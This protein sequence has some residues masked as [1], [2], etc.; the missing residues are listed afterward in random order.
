MSPHVFQQISPSLPLEVQNEILKQTYTSHL[1]D[2]DD[3]ERNEENKA[4][5]RQ[6]LITRRVSLGHHH[7]AAL[8]PPMILHLKSLE[9]I[10]EFFEDVWAF[11]RVFCRCCLSDPTSD[12]PH[13]DFC[14]LLGV[15]LVDSLGQLG[16]RS[17]GADSTSHHTLLDTVP[18][19]VGP[20]QQAGEGPASLAMP[21]VVGQREPNRVLVPGGQRATMPGITSSPHPFMHPPTV[22][23]SFAFYQNLH[24]ICISTPTH[25]GAMSQDT[26]AF[27]RHPPEPDCNSADNYHIW[28]T[29][30]PSAGDNKGWI[31][32]EHEMVGPWF[33][34]VPSLRRVLL[35]HCRQ[36]RTTRLGLQNAFAHHHAG[37]RGRK[38]LFVKCE[39]GLVGWQSAYVCRNLDGYRKDGVDLASDHEVN[40]FTGQLLPIY[41]NH[42]YQILEECTPPL[43]DTNPEMST[44]TYRLVVERAQRHADADVQVCTTVC[45]CHSPASHKSDMVA[46]SLQPTPTTMDNLPPE[47]YAEIGKWTV[48]SYEQ[49]LCQCHF[50]S[51]QPSQHIS[52]LAITALHFFGP[53]YQNLELIK[54]LAPTALPYMTKLQ[55]LHIWVGALY[56]GLLLSQVVGWW[57]A[58]NGN[59]IQVLGIYAG[60]NMAGWNDTLCSGPWS[61]SS[62]WISPLQQFPFLT[63]L[64][65]T[66]AYFPYFFDPPLPHSQ[67][68]WPQDHFGALQTYV[69]THPREMRSAELG[70]LEKLYTAIPTLQQV[71]YQYLATQFPTPG[72]AYFSHLT[73]SFKSGSGRL[74]MKTDNNAREYA[75]QREDHGPFMSRHTLEFRYWQVG[76]SGKVMST[77]G[78]LVVNMYLHHNTFCY[79]P[80]TVMFAAQTVLNIPE[81]LSIIGEACCPSWQHYNYGGVLYNSDLSE[82][83]ALW[84]VSRN[85]YH[86]FVPRLTRTAISLTTA[87]QLACLFADV[88]AFEEKCC[89][90]SLSGGHTSC[91]HVNFLNVYLLEVN[92]HHE[93]HNNARVW[94]LAQQAGCYMTGWLEL[95]VVIDSDTSTTVLEPS[96]IGGCLTSARSQPSASRMSTC[97]APEMSFYPNAHSILEVET[98]E[99]CQQIGIIR[100]FR[101]VYYMHHIGEIFLAK[102]L[103]TNRN[104]CAFQMQT[105]CTHTRKIW[106]R[107]RGSKTTQMDRGE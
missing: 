9:H 66:D 60:Q 10:R 5:L 27:Y 63:T 71:Y 86:H 42:E 3:V 45:C 76:N 99:L 69:V 35:E 41:I 93:I 64:I 1:P 54:T 7:L 81:L 19:A 52:F 31:K 104:L 34:D 89:R 49:E 100:S 6:L 28:L 48:I 12:C 25:V 77:V 62:A 85:F 43:G 33:E 24:T 75:R 107:L 82:V 70:S 106:T 98:W 61:Q 2:L 90:C 67:D 17:A 16:K 74:T 15:D 91:K 44:D 11:K 58:G 46:L 13:Y 30:L 51:S 57:S 53:T 22:Q 4:N 36:E 97:M 94:Q 72:G 73:L 56:Q 103:Q 50:P 23:I 55:E 79:S 29:N 83:L 78:T 38:S 92:M 14:Q 101:T 20:I 88:I 39:D 37:E 32:S 40:P 87:Y 65:I 102:W 96:D 21:S 80:S 68:L 47:I 59:N 105:Q 26:I 8:L 84:R 18:D 95:N